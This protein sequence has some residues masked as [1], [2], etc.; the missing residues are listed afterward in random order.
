MGG[1]TNQPER[2]YTS[3]GWGH[4]L[5]HSPTSLKGTGA[6]SSHPKTEACC[7]ACGPGCSCSV[8]W[9]FSS[10][11]FPLFYPSIGGLSAASPHGLLPST[12]PCCEQRPDATS[13]IFY[14]I[15][16]KISIFL[17]LTFYLGIVEEAKY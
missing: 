14:R 4:C 15:P 9:G 11:L 3:P 8:L 5:P 12:P 1:F 13:I 17:K 2:G 6:R 10:S 16:G 7:Q